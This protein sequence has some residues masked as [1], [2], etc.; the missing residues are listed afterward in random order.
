MRYFV[1]ENIGRHVHN[2]STIYTNSQQ[3]CIESLG[4]FWN[5][6]V[7]ENF[8][9]KTFSSNKSQY[10]K[11]KLKNQ[12][13]NMIGFTVRSNKKLWANGRALSVDWLSNHKTGLQTYKI[14]K[15]KWHQIINRKKWIHLQTWDKLYGTCSKKAFHTH[16]FMIYG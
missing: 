14:Y 3:I 12:S 10:L 7:V 11:L 4:P 8:Q 9:S 13:T 16:S 15:K 6:F 5:I 1:H 2:W